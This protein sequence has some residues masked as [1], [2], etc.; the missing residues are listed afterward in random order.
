MTVRLSGRI[1]AIIPARGGSKR[2]PRKNLHPILGEPMLGWT[3]AACRESRFIT[4]VVVTT[5]DPEIA[6]FARGRGAVVIDRPAALAE[7]AVYKME[8]IIHALDVLEGRGDQYDFIV[9]VQANSPEIRGAMLDAALQRVCD[10]GLW[11][12][13]SVD[14]QLVQNGAFRVM[15]PAVARQRSLSVHCGVMVADIVDVH[16]VDDVASVEQKLRQGAARVPHR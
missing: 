1:V 8:A 10:L 11:E 15:R 3:I 13:F 12:L 4:D 2:L 14:Q 6:E 5:E 7:D 9:S 16:T